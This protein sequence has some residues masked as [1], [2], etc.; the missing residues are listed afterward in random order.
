MNPYGPCDLPPGEPL[1]ESLNPPELVPEHLMRPPSPAPPNDFLNVQPQDPTST[2]HK[3]STTFPPDLIGSTTPFSTKTSGISEVSSI[4]DTPYLDSELHLD[5]L[6]GEPFPPE[7]AQRLTVLDRHELH[8]EMQLR[9]QILADER[10]SI[11]ADNSEF[12]VDETALAEPPRERKS[13]VAKTQEA[14]VT[15]EPYEDH[16]WF[17]SPCNRFRPDPP[18]D[19]DP[20]PEIKHA[21]P[22]YLRIG[23][24]PRIGR[25]PRRPGGGRRFTLNWKDYERRLRFIERIMADWRRSI[26]GV[27]VGNTRYHPPVFCPGGCLSVF[28]KENDWRHPGDCNCRFKGMLIEQ[29]LQILR[30]EAWDELHEPI[31]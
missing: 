8:F 26:Y 27:K 15:S 10:E 23:G 29:V 21:K 4:G 30:E 20:F 25:P 11:N 9:K 18:Y 7:I 3:S 6:D 5:Q 19:L 17:E 24:P 31:K 16:G 14:L 22:Y 12:M 13:E 1:Q 2:L 28:T